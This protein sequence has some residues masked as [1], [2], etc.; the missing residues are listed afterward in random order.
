M[1]FTFLFQSL[2][3]TFVRRSLFSSSSGSCH[4]SD[5]TYWSYVWLSAYRTPSLLSDVYHFLDPS[6]TAYPSHVGAGQLI[7]WLSWLAWSIKADLFWIDAD[8]LWM[9]CL[10]L[11]PSLSCVLCSFS[12]VPNFHPVSPSHS[13]HTEIALCFTETDLL[14]GFLAC[15]WIWFCVID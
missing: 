1:I 6:G 14:Q 8:F 12:L 2:S 15:V 4:G 10:L 5:A 11:P 9:V 13:C 7:T 3:D